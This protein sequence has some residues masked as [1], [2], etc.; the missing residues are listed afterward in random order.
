MHEPACAAVI[1]AAGASTRLGQPKQLLTIHGETLVHR[2]ARFALEAG[3]AP[4]HV[5]TG[6]L[7]DEIARELAPLAVRVVFNSVWQEGIASSIRCGLH[8]LEKAATS[9]VMF[10]VCDQV[11]LSTDLLQELRLA[12]ATHA[13]AIIASEYGGTFGVPAV[14][15]REYWPELQQLNGEQ[16]AKQMIKK[17]P[18]SV[19]CVSFIG[20]TAD[21]DIPGDCALLGNDA[22]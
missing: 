15:P 16:G 19:K 9:S 4:V 5:V 20:G 13:S 6:A 17:Y 7:N 8:S 10:L 3:C 12:S 11:R 21:I 22:F 2:T 18:H 14:F 1:L